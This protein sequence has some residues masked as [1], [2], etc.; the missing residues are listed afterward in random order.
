MCPSVCLFTLPRA[1]SELWTIQLSAKVISDH[2][3]PFTSLLLLGA[4]SILLR[5]LPPCTLHSPGQ[6]LHHPMPPLSSRDTSKGTIFL[7]LSPLGEG[8]RKREA[9]T[10]KKCFSQCERENNPSGIPPPMALEAFWGAG[11]YPLHSEDG[12][13]AEAPLAGWS[14]RCP[15][16]PLRAFSEN[17]GPESEPHTGLNPLLSHLVMSDSLYPHRL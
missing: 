14:H 6:D 15:P 1:M 17:L 7:C 5:P 3:L 11:P 2:H 12:G 9:G 4:P 16:T 10:A 13:T 8:K